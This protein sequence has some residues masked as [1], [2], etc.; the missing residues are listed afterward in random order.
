MNEKY[1]TLEQLMRYSE[2]INK[3]DK[4]YSDYND[5]SDYTKNIDIE[6][7]LKKWQPIKSKEETWQDQLEDMD[8]SVI[9]KFLRKKKLER[10]KQ[11]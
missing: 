3:Y 4:N 5:Y 7:L 6:D 10:I 1:T 8:I 2:N 11:D 9:E